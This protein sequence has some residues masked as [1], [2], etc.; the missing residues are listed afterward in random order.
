MRHRARLILD[1]CPPRGSAVLDY[2]LHLTR[3]IIY[4]QISQ[5]RFASQDLT[6]GLEVAH[7]DHLAA[8]HLREGHHV[9][10]TS[11]PGVPKGETSKTV[12][13]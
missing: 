1:L 11:A 2:F 5:G 10:Q 9:V 8:L 6:D 7:D 12:P 3:C 4:L 13:T